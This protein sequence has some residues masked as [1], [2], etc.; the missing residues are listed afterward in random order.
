MPK[1][2]DSGMPAPLRERRW[3]ER[4]KSNQRCISAL[5]GSSVIMPVTA[6]RCCVMGSIMAWARSASSVATSP[7]MP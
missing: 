1:M 7:D 3:I 5:K 6:S 4:A 2:N